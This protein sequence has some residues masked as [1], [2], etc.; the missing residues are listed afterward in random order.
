MIWVLF[1]EVLCSFALWPLYYNSGHDAKE[2]TGGQD[3]P[4]TQE[5]SHKDSG[6]MGSRNGVEG[7]E[8]ILVRGFYKAGTKTIL[9][10]RDE[11]RVSG[12]RNST[13]DPESYDYAQEY[14]EEPLGLCP[15]MT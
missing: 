5:H 11:I 10:F 2:L 12:S 15:S 9:R 13:L 1:G 6:S 14:Y 4:K 8:T 7:R 3:Y